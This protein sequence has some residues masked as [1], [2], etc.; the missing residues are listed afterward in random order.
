MFSPRRCSETCLTDKQ[1]RHNRKPRQRVSLCIHAGRLKEQEVI[2]RVEG[3]NP[4]HHPSTAENRTRLNDFVSNEVNRPV[5]SLQ[6]KKHRAVRHCRQPRPPLRASVLLNVATFQRP[7][8]G[9]G[10]GGVALST[11]THT[12]VCPTTSQPI[13]DENNKPVATHAHAVV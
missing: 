13:S 3:S 12:P 9:V 1:V 2:S 10:L 8:G 5:F 4:R 11:P 7:D 6:M